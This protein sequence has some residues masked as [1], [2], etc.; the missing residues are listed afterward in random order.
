MSAKGLSISSVFLERLQASVFTPEV[1]RLIQDITTCTV[2][3]EE[4]P[5][6]PRDLQ[7]ERGLELF[8]C[9]SLYFRRQLLTVKGTLFRN[10]KSRESGE[11]FHLVRLE[12]SDGLLWLRLRPSH[13]ALLLSPFHSRFLSTLFG[14]LFLHHLSPTTEG[15][16]GPPFF[17]PYSLEEQVVGSYLESLEWSPC[18]TI[19]LDAQD[20]PYIGSLLHS[21]ADLRR[22]TLP[23][24]GREDAIIQVWRLLK[25]L[26]YYSIE[27]QRLFTGFAFLPGNR[28][29]AHYQRRY[30]TLLLYHE[31]HRLSLTQGV[32]SLKQ[33]LINADGRRTF[34]AVYG[35]RI[36]GLLELVRGTHRQLTTI[37]AWREALPLATIS[38]RGWVNFWIAL[39][40]RH[41]P[42]ITLSLLELRHGRLQIP[43]FQDI[44]WQE[45]ED[46]LRGICPV[47][48][49]Q[50]CLGRL[51]NLLLMIRHS[52]RGAIV[53]LGVDTDNLE[54][55]ELPLDNEIRLSEPVGLEDRWLRHLVGLAKSDGALVFNRHFQAVMFRARLKAHSPR[56]APEADDLGSGIRHQVTREFT[57]AV[58][59]V[60]GLCVSQDGYVSLYRH[61]RLVSRLF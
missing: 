51:K 40:G 16:A 26:L 37:R 27:G 31:K 8:P 46:Q 17:M 34:L 53:L 48:P 22:C 57:A 42:K 49:N 59:Q 25:R 6:S 33:L 12:L 54:S 38:H 2:H 29:L 1:Q 28:S 44:F 23:G 11:I 24:S 35:G 7:G 52:G 5:L 61:G 60:M 10:L 3:W 45:L 30:P 39:R 14:R 50:T 21:A 32:E 13:T 4:A 41:N 19:K 56:L 36:V 18:A 9:L 55:L 15:A 47:A 43:L 58:P 20:N